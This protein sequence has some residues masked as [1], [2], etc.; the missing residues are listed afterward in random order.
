MAAA[1]AVTIKSW[2]VFVQYPFS[3]SLNFPRSFLS[4]NMKGSDAAVMRLNVLNELRWLSL[5]HYDSGCHGL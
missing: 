4:L 3:I 2:L 5:L 1:K